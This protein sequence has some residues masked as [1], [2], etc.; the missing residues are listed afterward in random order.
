MSLAYEAALRSLDPECA[1]PNSGASRRIVAELAAQPLA[2][3]TSYL[4]QSARLGLGNLVRCALEAGVSPDT[5]SRDE[6]GST[7]LLVLAAQYGV[8]RTLKALLSGGANKELADKNGVTALSWAAC[9]GH[10]SCLQA[11]L[12]AGA[13]ANVQDTLGNTPLTYAVANKHVECARALL[14]DSDLSLI[15]RMGHTAFHAAVI[16]ASEKC[17]E[18]LLP[19]YDVDVRIVQGVEPSGEVLRAFNMTA[20]HIACHKGL[21]TIGKALLSRGANR[22]AR[23]SRQMTPLHCVAAHGHLS[24][25]VM[26]VANQW[27]QWAPRQCP[28]DAC[29]GER[30]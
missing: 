1:V 25:V 29:R 22:M 11:L 3:R 28:H 2:F 17:F 30:G 26:L 18:L 4:R 21:L 7:P 14:S 5:T 27:A 12:D 9:F 23:D 10:L 8:T 16:T 6:T 20:L 13:L 24:C 19:R 15:T